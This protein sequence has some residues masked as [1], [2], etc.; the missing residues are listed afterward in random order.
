MRYD[1]NLPPSVRELDR[2][3][4]LGSYDLVQEEGCLSFDG[5]TLVSLGGCLVL[6]RSPSLTG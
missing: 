3:L 4:V 2:G 1:E 5:P 6:G